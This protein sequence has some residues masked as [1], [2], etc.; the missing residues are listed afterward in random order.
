MRENNNTEA[1]SSMD[2][3]WQGMA[4]NALTSSEA[5]DHPALS[6]LQAHAQDNPGGLDIG[7]YSKMHHRHNR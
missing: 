7:C 4:R 5:S 1:L 6:R 2:T 3:E